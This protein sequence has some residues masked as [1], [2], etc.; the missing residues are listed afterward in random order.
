MIEIRSK[1][2]V[3]DIEKVNKHSPLQPTKDFFV[4]LEPYPTLFHHMD[5]IKTEIAQMDSPVAHEHLETLQREIAH[6][7]PIWND[8]REESDNMVSYA[9]IWIFFTPGDLVLREDDLGNLWLLVLTSTARSVPRKM[10]NGQAEKR[11]MIF[12]VWYLTLDQVD[13]TLEKK[14]MRIDCVEFSGKRHI[15]SLPVYPIRY[16]E[17]SMRERIEEALAK[18][19]RRWQE[20]IAAAPICQHHCGLAFMEG[21]KRTA[22]EIFRV[23]Y[24]ISIHPA[25]QIIVSD[26]ES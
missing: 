18:R 12:C 7:E 15:T 5:D 23:S 9:M 16:Q 19:G 11:H 14:H 25:G 10:E 26:F 17:D 1:Y 21:D 20:L 6:V 4:E 2:L 8:A 22:R 24:S 13:G 3:D